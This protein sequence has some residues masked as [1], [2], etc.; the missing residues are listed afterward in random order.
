MIGVS[1]RTRCSS[2]RSRLVRLWIPARFASGIGSAGAGRPLGAGL[3]RLGHTDVGFGERLYIF[4]LMIP[5]TL[6]LVDLRA[7]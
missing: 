5:L 4:G 3:I 7:S 6:D 2:A 1:S